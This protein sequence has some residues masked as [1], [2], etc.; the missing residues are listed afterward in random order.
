MSRVLG[1]CPPHFPGIKGVRDVS[2]L[3]FDF[4]HSFIAVINEREMQRDS[5]EIRHGSSVL[6]VIPAIAA[7]G[8][9]LSA[10]H[11][12]CAWES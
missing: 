9:N 7:E 10:R 2:L 11:V 3:L 6:S 1:K 4:L 8:A 5:A 12:R